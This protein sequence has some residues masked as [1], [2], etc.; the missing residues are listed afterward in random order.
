[1]A[2]VNRSDRISSVSVTLPLGVWLGVENSL[3]N[4]RYELQRWLVQKTS[5]PQHTRQATAHAIEE[6]TLA[7]DAIVDRTSSV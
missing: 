6:I 1:M 5:A 3:K 7:I 2:A 4:Q